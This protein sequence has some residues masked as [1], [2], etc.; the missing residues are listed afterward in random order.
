M[1]NAFE[2]D[3]K[4]RGWVELYAKTGVFQINKVTG[5]WDEIDYGHNVIDLSLLYTEEEFHKELRSKYDSEHDE[6]LPEDYDFYKDSLELIDWWEKDKALDCCDVHTY[7]INYL[8]DPGNPV[9]YI[10]DPEAEDSAYI[11]ETDGFITMSKY[12]CKAPNGS[13]CIPNQC[14]L[15]DEYSEKTEWAFTLPPDLWGDDLIEGMEIIKVDK[16]IYNLSGI[17]NRLGGV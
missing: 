2:L 6:C 13:P 4:E 10:E 3:M 15:D 11:G 16:K 17:L 14:C 7:L 8:P 9:T 5:M 1:T 12:V